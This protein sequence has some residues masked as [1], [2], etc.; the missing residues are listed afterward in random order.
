MQYL[1]QRV[2]TTIAISP[3]SWVL[4]GIMNV[5]DLALPQQEGSVRVSYDWITAAKL[6]RIELSELT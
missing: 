1:H 3:G 5:S 4:S 2:R 6:E